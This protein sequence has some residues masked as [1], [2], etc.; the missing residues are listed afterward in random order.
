MI[1]IYIQ[2]KTRCRDPVSR[3]TSFGAKIAEVHFLWDT[4][5]SH[6]IFLEFSIISENKS[7]INDLMV[8]H[9]TN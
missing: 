9:E 1:H 5:I 8:R 6:R 7:A 3:L 4:D 2:V